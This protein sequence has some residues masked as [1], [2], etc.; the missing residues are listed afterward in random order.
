MGSA[1]P[2]V[3]FVTQTETTYLD[4]GRLGGI[5]NGTTAFICNCS[6]R[7]PTIKCSPASSSIWFKMCLLRCL[8]MIVL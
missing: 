2:F 3:E 4:I 6:L 8:V 7:I 5:S 1:T